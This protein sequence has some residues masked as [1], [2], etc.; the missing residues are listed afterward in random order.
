MSNCNF[1]FESEGVLFIKSH[2][3]TCAENEVSG[4][5]HL[6]PQHSTFTPNVLFSIVLNYNS[7]FVAGSFCPFNTKRQKYNIMSASYTKFT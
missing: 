3:D 2:K 4:F 1:Y 5:R 7:C 6:F